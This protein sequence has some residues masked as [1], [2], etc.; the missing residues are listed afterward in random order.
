MSHVT[1]P[2]KTMPG[3]RHPLP[4]GTFCDQHSDVAAV[5]RIQGETTSDRAEYIDMCQ[6]CLDRFQLFQS[7]EHPGTCHKCG[8]FAET[9]RKYQDRDEGLNGQVY[10]VCDSCVSEIPSLVAADAH[11]AEHEHDDH[12]GE[13]PT[14]FA[15]IDYLGPRSGDR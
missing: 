15:D 4:A 1:G 13:Q 14:D 8:M 5:A 6:V 7:E 12:T 9:L 3:T 10:D 11:E 2:V